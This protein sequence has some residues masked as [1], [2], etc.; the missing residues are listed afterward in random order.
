MPGTH[1]DAP[2]RFGLRWIA[3]ALGVGIAVATAVALAPS[4]SA[5]T[6]V[7]AQLSLT[8]VATQGNILGGTQIGVHPGDTVVFK[9]APVPTAGLDNIPA[10]GPLL[11]NLVTSLLGT[12]YQVVLHLPA[13]FPG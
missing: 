1:T 13:S 7:N 2:R 3:G 5:S 12:Q 4:S 6:T 11:N 8:G 10:L 9:A